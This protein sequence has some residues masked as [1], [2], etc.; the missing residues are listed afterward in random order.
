MKKFLQN[1]PVPICGLMLG[2]VAVGNLLKSVGLF[3]LGQAFGIVGIIVLLLVMLKIIFAWDSVA[4]ALKDNVVASVAPTFSMGWMVACT[5][6]ADFAVTKYFWL[7]GVAIHMLLAIYFTVKFLRPSVLKFDDIY[8]S[9]YIVYVGPGIIPITA[10]KFFPAVGQAFFYPVLIIYAMM[11]PI[12]IWRALF[13]GD[14]AEGKLPLMMVIAAPTSLCLTGF[15]NA[16]SHGSTTLIWVLVVVAQFL[17]L[18]MLIFMARFLSKLPFYPSYSAFTFPL[19]ISATAFL[20][21]VKRLNLG[22]VWQQLGYVEVL[23]ATLTVTYVL[24]GY[25][26]F[27]IQKNKHAV[28]SK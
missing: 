25:I 12:V 2:L 16:F 24:V 21:T 9:W 4:A 17:L 3:I 6:F 28:L 18:S 11:L 20:G 8:P 22:D 27:L 1:L 23:I 15:L 5:Y 19:V 7:V 10:G 26:K 14:I 13:G